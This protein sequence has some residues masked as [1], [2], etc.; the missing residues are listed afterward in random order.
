MTPSREK[1]L[2]KCGE[3]EKWLREMIEHWQGIIQGNKWALNND[4]TI[5]NDKDKSYFLSHIR[6]Y[7]YIV[8]AYRHELARLKGMDRVVVPRKAYIGAWG[9]KGGLCKCGKHITDVHNYCPWCGNE[10]TKYRKSNVDIFDYSGTQRIFVDK[11]TGVQYI[12]IGIC[13]QKCMSVRLDIDGK[14]MVDKGVKK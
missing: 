12:V 2:A 14:P 7:K 1:Y 5:L 10:D 4:K 13:D 8:S 9:D 11:E 3:K 6:K